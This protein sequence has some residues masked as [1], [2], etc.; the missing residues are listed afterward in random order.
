MA[1]SLSSAAVAV[2]AGFPSPALARPQDV[3]Y[4][5]RQ[6][7]GDINTMDGTVGLMLPRHSDAGASVPMTVSV[8]SPMTAADY[9]QVVRIYGTEN[10][11]PR[12]LT[13]RFT[14]ACGKA[15]VSTRI[16]LDGAQTIIAIAR[17]STG[18]H[19]RSQQKVS[20][21]FGACANLGGGPGFGDDFVPTARLAVPKTAKTGEVFEIRTLISHPMESGLRLNNF[22]E[23]EPL[24]IIE[25][26]IC[27]MNGETVFEATLEP[28][29]STNPYLSFF[30]AARET[31]DIEVD[32]IDTTGDVYSKTARMVVI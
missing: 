14:P 16:R 7:F 25:R 6:D 2:W 26:I 24:R 4:A 9:P 19:Y 8:A 13:A 1:G 32:W 30:L 17:M 10:P 28:A 18:A 22:N 29:I 21:T 20:V 11:R 15:S 5:I 27:R 3:E 31:S 23:Y 12:L